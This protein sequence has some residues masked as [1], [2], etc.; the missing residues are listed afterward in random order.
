[1][2][3]QLRNFLDSLIRPVHSHQVETTWENT[4]TAI[5]ESVLPAYVSIIENMDT[6]ETNNSQMLK[7]MTTSKFYRGLDPKKILLLQKRFFNDVLSESR[8]VSKLIKKDVAEVITYKTGKAQETTILTLVSDISAMTFYS[9]D[10]I[11]MMVLDKDVEIPKKRV[12]EINSL[13]SMF[14]S[15]H[16]V[17]GEDFSKYVKNINKVSTSKVEQD[18][19]PGIMDALFSDTGLLVKIPFTSG[20]INNPLYHVRM[21]VIDKRVERYEVLKEKRTV[22]GLKINELKVK[23]GGGNDPK[24]AKHIEYYEDKI[25]AIEANIREFEEDI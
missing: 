17:Y 20:F 9:L 14:A 8:N 18:K 4:I 19:P 7:I 21:W 16:E 2:Y 13:V 3:P 5:E 24:L 22:L 10:F 12:E 25:S 11:Y 23:Q 6:V 15:M 1:M